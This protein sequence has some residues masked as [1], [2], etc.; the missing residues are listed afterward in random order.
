MKCTVADEKEGE[1]FISM[2]DAVCCKVFGIDLGTIDVFKEYFFQKGV[3]YY[4]SYQAFTQEYGAV[5]EFF[6]YA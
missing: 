3:F 5:L 4:K 6:K 2:R 1:A